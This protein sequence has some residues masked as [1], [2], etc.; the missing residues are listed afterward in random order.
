MVLFFDFILTLK[1]LVSH[2]ELLDTYFFS[3]KLF[4]VMGIK[5][6]V[7]LEA[8]LKKYLYSVCKR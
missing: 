7:G 3:P 4:E 1:W 6:W 2:A 5:S 8:D